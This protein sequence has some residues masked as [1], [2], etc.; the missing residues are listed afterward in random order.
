MLEHA[1][2]VGT[3]PGFHDLTVSDAVDI[4]SRDGYV[5][6]C[7]G[8]SHKLAPMRAGNCPT[9]HDHIPFSNLVINGEM[10][11][12]ESGKESGSG[13][14]E[15]LKGGTVEPARIVAQV[16]G[17][18]EFIYCAHVPLV[19]E[20]IKRMEENLLVGRRVTGGTGYYRR[21]A[22]REISAPLEE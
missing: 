6:F 11:I 4:D 14:L 10:E 13:L 18:V 7:W 3:P 21:C 16:V 17:G 20:V 19:P 8:D 22:P 2:G 5:V 15:L 1:Q 9:F 12:R